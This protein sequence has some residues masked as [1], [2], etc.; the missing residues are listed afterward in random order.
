MKNTKSLLSNIVFWGSIWGIMEATL[1]YALHW[2]PQMIS[3][4]IMFPIGAS[5]LLLAYKVNPNRQTVMGVGLVASSI[6]LVNLLMPNI[7]V[8]KVLNPIISIIIQTILFAIIVP[9]FINKRIYRRSLLI[10]GTSILWRGAYV[11]FMAMQYLGNGY[12]QEYMSTY[13]KAI[14]FIL[15]NG[16]LSGLFAAL[17]IW[18]IC[19]MSKSI[20]TSRKFIPKPLVSVAVM[21]LAVV[22]TYFI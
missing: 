5:I 1:G 4:N 8:F 20:A 3:G 14:S 18:F 22:L 10:I 19:P 16:M 7:S 12:I 17:L 21:L 2:L 6:K 9:V 15:I 13:K 11:A